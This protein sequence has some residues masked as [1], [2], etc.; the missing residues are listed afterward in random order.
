MIDQ[1]DIGATKAQ[2]GLL[3]FS[4]IARMQFHLNDYHTKEDL[5]EA[6]SKVVWH[7]TDTYTNEAIDMLIMEGLNKNYGARKGVP[8]IAVIVTDGQSTEPTL[9]A[10]A[11][12][13]LKQTKIIT[14]AVG[15]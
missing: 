3:T 6:L 8:Q 4:D 10:A 14:F 9:T 7:G 13:A 5:I 12:D 15:M 2:I 11:V 1:L